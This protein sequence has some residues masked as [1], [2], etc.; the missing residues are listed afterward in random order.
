[1][2]RASRTEA[3]CACD[4][5]GPRPGAPLASGADATAWPAYR[6]NVHLDP[7]AGVIDCAVEIRSPQA[8]T[9]S[10]ARDLKIRR[11]VA[12]G[13]AAAFEE[14]P[15]ASAATSRDVT[16]AGS[17]PSRLVIEY[18]GP[19]LAESYPKL[20]SQVNMVRPELVGLAGYVGWYPRLMTLSKSAG[21][22]VR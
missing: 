11:I 19:I 10:L 15:S 22:A 8:S 14:N 18:S 12:D 17:A 20:V 1:L 13:K 5:G 21:A 6:L 9:F 16:V 2:W 3:A 4:P 7:A